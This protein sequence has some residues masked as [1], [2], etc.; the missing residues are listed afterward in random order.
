[1]AGA[2]AGAKTRDKEGAGAENKLFWLRNTAIISIMCT[3][4]LYGLLAAPPPPPSP[5]PRPV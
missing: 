2:G 4:R 5:D 3:Q 1:M